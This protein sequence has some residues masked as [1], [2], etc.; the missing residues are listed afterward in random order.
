MIKLI[1][2][3]HAETDYAKQ[4]RYYSYTDISLN[5]CG[6]R[7]AKILKAKL[8]D[9]SP[10]LIF[11]SP[12]KRTHKTA[13][14]LFPDKEIFLNTSLSELNFGRWEGLTFNE[15]C[16]TDRELY[17]NWLKNPCKHTPPQG[18]TFLNLEKRIAA[19]LK[20][21][22]ENNQ[23]KTV[24]CV[25]HAGPIK[26]MICYLLKKPFH[27]FWKIDVDLASLSYFTIKNKKVTDYN[28]NQ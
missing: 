16:Q 2:I 27:D 10:D 18:E 20:K 3:R 26:S 23:S 19:F 21:I 4:K 22:F 12:S 7:Q 24:V 9:L 1:L 15:I 28:L 5:K 14:L 13:Q 25:S 11:S 17:L 8:S 6:I